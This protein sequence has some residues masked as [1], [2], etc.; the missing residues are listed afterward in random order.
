MD[1]GFEIKDM[2]LGNETP[3]EIMDGDNMLSIGDRPYH[4]LSDALTNHPERALDALYVSS[5]FRGTT[6]SFDTTK[7]AVRAELAKVGMNRI[8]YRQF[9]RYRE[10]GKININTMPM[11]DYGSNALAKALIGSK[12]VETHFGS[13]G[14]F[15]NPFY[16]NPRTTEHAVFGLGSTG[17]SFDSV[18]PSGN[19]N[20]GGGNGNQ[21]C[22]GNCNAGSAYTDQRDYYPLLGLRT[23]IRLGNT[24][25]IRSSV[26]GVWITV[27]VTDQTTTLETKRRLFAIVDR[28]IPTAFSPG[29]DLNTRNVSRLKRF[30]E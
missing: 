29:E 8:P 18:A 22:N 12:K 21:N 6:Q 4:Y 28:S 25:T 2:L 23:A 7:S 20:G 3:D 17:I 19:G 13:S 27:K 15:S 5:R 30:I 1:R 10:P 24:A 11:A 16:S 9:S 14:S 26:F